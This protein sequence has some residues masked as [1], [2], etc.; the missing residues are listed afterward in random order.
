MLINSKNPEITL[1]ILWEKARK[2]EKEILEEISKKFN[3]LKKYEIS[4][5]PEKFLNNLSSFYSDDVYQRT[6]Q[7]EIRGTGEFLMVLCEDSN[8]KYEQRETNHGLIYVNV[9]AIDL[10]KHIR[11]NIL[12]GGFVF[13]SSDNMDEAR[14]DTVLL[15]GQS[16]SDILKK[17]NL[18][19]KTIKLKQD[20]PCVAGWKNMEQ[21]F[22]VLNEACNYVVLWGAENLPKNFF[23][24][25]QNGDIDLLTNNLQRLIAIL[26]D[27]NNL[28]KN[29][30]VFYNWVVV[31]GEKNLFHA[32]FVGDEYFDKSWQYKQLE[33]RV[34]NQ[35]GIY[36]LSDEMQ[37]YSLLYHGLIHKTN[38]KKYLSI[39]TN[40]ASKINVDFKDEIECLKFQLY[41]WMKNHN[42]KY[43]KH[44]DYGNLHQEN[45][46][47]KKYIKKHPDYY[48]FQNYWGTSII[49]KK[50]ISLYPELATNLALRFSPFI[51]LETHKL[52]IDSKQFNVFKKDLKNDA[53][54]VT[55]TKRYGKIGRTRCFYKKNKLYIKKDF[56]GLTQKVKSKHLIINGYE[57]VRKFYNGKSYYQLLEESLNDIEKF[58][59]YLE[60]YIQEIF[61]R[62]Q[63][64]KSDKLIGKSFDMLPQNC[65]VLNENEH[66]FIFFDF[67]YSII[68]GMDKSYMI[69]RCL[70]HLHMN[71]NKKEI[72]DYLCTKFNLPNTF[73]WCQ[74]FDNHLNIFNNI[75]K[76]PLFFKQ[77]FLKKF[78]LKILSKIIKS[79]QILHKINYCLSFQQRKWKKYF[80]E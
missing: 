77:N 14:H 5:T 27:N 36:V 50:I 65:I 63:D 49:E 62:F 72:Y 16:I 17:E 3:I 57:K 28:R 74:S 41:N 40:L 59:H 78:L 22:Y 71:F 6:D 66:K 12:D 30:F 24:H 43:T 68:G 23:S 69:Y 45:V 75:E 38:Y 48:I 7:K 56:I 10:K 33:S 31:G 20:L 15:T 37:F 76:E 52:S 26:Q 19:G 42:Y 46:F 73:A 70:A 44:L 55:Y 47:N 34:L 21:V 61:Y 79:P 67:E 13:H 54:F 35:N 51:E 64:T 60:I 11:E 58:K 9:K 4:W 53:L 32:K 29:A 1:F 80:K 8:P 25:K 18:D 2:K 39:F